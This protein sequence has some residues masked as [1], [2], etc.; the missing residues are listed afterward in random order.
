ML[1]FLKDEKYA[2]QLTALQAK[3]NSMILTDPLNVLRS[4]IN[5][6]LRSNLRNDLLPQLLPHIQ[7]LFQ[8]KSIN[9]RYFFKLAFESCFNRNIREEWFKF[10]Q[11]LFTNG[12]EDLKPVM[13]EGLG[14][15][16]YP[17][18]EAISLLFNVFT[19]AKPNSVDMKKLMFAF[20]EN[21][22]LL[23]TVEKNDFLMQRLGKHLLDV[24]KEEPEKVRISSVYQLIL[25]INNIR[26]RN[27]VLY[28]ALETL[29]INPVAF[30][31]FTQMQASI[32]LLNKRSLSP[33]AAES[34]CK[35]IDQLKNLQ[36]QATKIK[37]YN[38][39]I[40][41]SQ[42]FT[43]TQLDTLHKNYNM[44][45]ENL[46]NPNPRMVLSN[47]ASILAFPP[48]II[49][50]DGE[51]I[52]KTLGDFIQ[53]G[54]TNSYLGLLK[55]FNPKTVSKNRMLYIPMVREV[56]N[57]FN[58][59]SVRMPFPDILDSLEMFS[60]LGVKNPAIYNQIIEVTSFLILTPFH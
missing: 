57:N 42:E 56:S 58:H 60:R 47:L 31:T 54:N 12:K 18:N 1:S 10:L 9:T 45:K 35:K 8:E 36:D 15:V 25:K 40:N 27:S 4:L 41:Q 53:Q 22:R 20:K 30:D 26:P 33:R 43:E 21:Q 7:R 3:V 52:K 2:S 51:F 13:I 34:V 16:E 5:T 11:T 49:K 59:F 23:V 48:E 24:T 38:Q 28:P 17:E 14:S 37:L 6:E 32:F 39:S 55:S 50:D 29:L 46:N 19:I 44:V